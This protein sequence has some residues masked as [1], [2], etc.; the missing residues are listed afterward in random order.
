[1]QS[2]SW[3]KNSEG[4]LKWLPFYRQNAVDT[5]LRL[6]WEK[7]Q[8]RLNYAETEQRKANGLTLGEKIPAMDSTR[9]TAIAGIFAGGDMYPRYHDKTIGG[10]QF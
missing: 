4:Q 1:M 2:K 3:N 7:S 9:R 5:T 10:R 8:A 6:S